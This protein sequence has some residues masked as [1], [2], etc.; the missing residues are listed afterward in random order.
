[1]EKVH[2]KNAKGIKKVVI[3]KDIKHENYKDVLLNSEQN[4]HKMKT[5]W[6]NNHQLGSYEINK[7][8]YLAF[9]IN[10][11]HLMV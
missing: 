10:D 7:G 4:H 5:I 1:M 6:S 11:I 8:H 9:M 2:G 3:K